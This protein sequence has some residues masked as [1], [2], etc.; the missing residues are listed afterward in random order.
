MKVKI[1]SINNCKY[2]ELI[3]SIFDDQSIS[4]EEI[5]VLRMGE[6]GSGISFAEYLSLREDI[7]VAKKCNFPQIYV[8]DE[9]IGDLKSAITYFKNENK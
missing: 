4:Y 3:K 8:D 1:Y 9:Y 5:K 6:S 7:P 2:C